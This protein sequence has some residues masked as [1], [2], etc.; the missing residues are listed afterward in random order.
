[1]N[2]LLSSKFSDLALEE[3]ELFELLLEKEGFGPAQFPIVP[4]ANVASALLS[5]TQERLWKLGGLAPGKPLGNVDLSF[6]LTGPFQVSAAQRALDQLVRRHEMLRTTFDV[7]DGAV[8]Q[9]IH[10][11]DTVPIRTIDLRENE[12]SHSE[13]SVRAMA[14]DEV[15]HVFDVSREFLIRCAWIRI[16]E[17]ESYLVITM[18]HLA[19]DGCAMRVFL[20]EFSNR[21]RAALGEPVDPLPPMPV[22]YADFAEWEVKGLQ[23]GLYDSQF[24]YWKTQLSGAAALK[25]PGCATASPSSEAERFESGTERF[26]FSVQL[27]DLIRQFSRAHGVTVYTTFVSLLNVLFHHY[28]GQNDIVIGTIISNRSRPETERL[29]GNLG[30]QLFLR[31]TGIK[32]VPFREILWRTRDVILAAHANAD[33]P[34]QNLEERFEHETRANLPPFEFMF[35]CR[36]TPLEQN[37]ELTYVRVAP[38]AVE[39]SVA[40]V[41]LKLDISDGA[42]CLKGIVEFH[43]SRFSRKWIRTFIEDLRLVAECELRA[44]DLTSAPTKAQFPNTL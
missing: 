31:S 42:E 6:R 8:R 30:N 26:H 27:S 33:L 17:Y 21:Y 32:D 24:D 1:M 34:F 9:R 12:E 22:Q 23:A 29:V 37:I 44:A 18:H 7:V 5:S 11:P 13:A 4:R 14:N 38:F 35:V 19:V 40:P 36:E 41:D 10:R 20:T 25:L 15:R 28:T 39:V 43:R 3:R 16:S 2:T